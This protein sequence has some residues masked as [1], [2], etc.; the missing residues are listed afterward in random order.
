LAFA[1]AGNDPELK[2]DDLREQAMLLPAV[3][4]ATASS[5]ELTR[6]KLR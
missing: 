1:Q 4:S 6:W 5:P 2:H 3:G